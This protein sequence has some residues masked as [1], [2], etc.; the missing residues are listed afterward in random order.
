MTKRI[1]STIR[2]SVPLGVAGLLA[3][4][5]AVA[6]PAPALASDS[7]GKC[8]Y[9]GIDSDNGPCME[10][11]NSLSYNVVQMWASREM[12]LWC[13][14]GSPTSATH[15]IILRPNDSFTCQGD[16]VKVQ[17]VQAAC[18]TCEFVSACGSGKSLLELHPDP[19]WEQKGQTFQETKVTEYYE[20][21]CQ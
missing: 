3:L 19:D 6:A 13:L 16:R 8:V 15:K 14:S 9:A 4:L 12:N 5:F 2:R 20:Q 11:K 10:V 7:Q 17:R 21:K 1:S 18:N